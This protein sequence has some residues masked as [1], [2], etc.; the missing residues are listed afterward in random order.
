MEYKILAW[1]ADL[2]GRKV[3][4]F[5]S[6]HFLLYIYLHFGLVFGLVM[7]SP[8]FFFPSF[9]PQGHTP[10]SVAAIIFGVDIYDLLGLY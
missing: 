3:G 10:I 7:S 2:M 6:L 8:V 4:S 9:L 1:E 5:F